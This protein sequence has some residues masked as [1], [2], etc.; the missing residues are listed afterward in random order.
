M[1]RILLDQ[2]FDQNIVRGLLDRLPDLDLVH[3]EHLGIK[4]FTD[5]KVL[6]FAANEGRIVFTHDSKTFPGFA[7][8][9]IGSGE[10]MCGVIVVPKRMSLKK[11][12]DELEL[13]LLCLADSEWEGAVLR[14]PI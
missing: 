3:T 10:R 5:D 8:A 11:A 7:Y 1:I 6:E 12:I 2:N 14:L 9:R 4:R 13:L